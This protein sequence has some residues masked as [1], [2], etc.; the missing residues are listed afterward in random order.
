LPFLQQPSL[1]ASCVM[2][3]EVELLSVRL[4]CGPTHRSTGPPASCACRFPPRCA[5]RRPVTLH[6][7]AQNHAK[8]VTVGE[9]HPQIAVAPFGDAPQMARAAG[10]VSLGRETEPAGEVAGVAVVADLARSRRCSELHRPRT[11]EVRSDC[12]K[13]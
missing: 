6:V 7:S 8:T 1:V 13:F 11:T 4:Q 9:Q 10:G 12:L 2:A 5:L 3:L